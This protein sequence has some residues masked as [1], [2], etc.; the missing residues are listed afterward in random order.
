MPRGRDRGRGR[1]R[2]GRSGRGRS[3][4][5]RPQQPK[6]DNEVKITEELDISKDVKKYFIGNGSVEQHYNA[7]NENKHKYAAGMVALMKDGV[8]ITQSK[9]Y[10][11]AKKKRN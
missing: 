11:K 4:G 10:K 7:Q 1:G 3:G 8:T 2:G 6:D 9:S 5:R